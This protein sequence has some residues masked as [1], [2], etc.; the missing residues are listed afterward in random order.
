MW[1]SR[2][3]SDRGGRNSGGASPRPTSVFDHC[4]KERNEVKR[5]QWAKTQACCDG[6]SSVSAWRSRQAPAASQ[7]RPNP[8][9]LT[10]EGAMRQPCRVRT[11]LPWCEGTTLHKCERS[12]PC[13][14]ERAPHLL[15][16]TSC[17]RSEQTSIA[18]QCGRQEPLPSVREILFFCCMLI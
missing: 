1:R 5:Q 8:A 13:A 6:F 14:W 7:I 3:E 18:M 15:C 4:R 12:E 16:F 2:C 10:P 11:M 9:G 17:E